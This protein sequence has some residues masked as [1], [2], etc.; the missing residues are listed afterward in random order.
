MSVVD[1][2]QR[3]G[4]CVHIAHHLPGRIRLRLA[5]LDELPAL[6]TKEQSLLDQA[7]N[8]RDLLDSIPGIVSIR[9]NL[10]ARSCTVEYDHAA[11]PFQAWPDFLAG[12]RSNEADVLARI[13]EEKYT[14]VANA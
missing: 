4:A 7:R 10:M 3:F 5:Q 13:I 1:K 14:E 2:I 11:I 12:I 9:V 8:F 6:D